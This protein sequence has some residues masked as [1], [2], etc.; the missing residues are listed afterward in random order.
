MPKTK[1]GW[2]S[3]IA[4]ALV[5][6]LWT[7]WT[8]PI[9][10]LG[11]LVGMYLDRADQ[12]AAAASKDAM[13]EAERRIVA[14]I[15]KTQAEVARNEAAASKAASASPQVYIEGLGAVGMHQLMRDLD[16]RFAR[17]RLTSNHT[18]MLWR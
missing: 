16:A 9:L 7:V 13:A 11:F 5:G 3:W 4:I 15:Q 1:A 8:I 14:K 10:L 6:S 12:R 2:A 17:Q 18:D